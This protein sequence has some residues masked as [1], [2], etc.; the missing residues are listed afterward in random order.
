MARLGSKQPYEEYFVSFDFTAVIGSAALAT[1]NVIAYD[2]TGATA[3][4]IVTEVANQT[5]ATA[6]VYIWVKGGVADNEYKITCQIETNS[7][8][9][10]KY[11]LDATLPIAEL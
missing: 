9:A 3:T 10:E 11:E 2:S 6:C 7:S 1:A 5:M 8:P 4:S